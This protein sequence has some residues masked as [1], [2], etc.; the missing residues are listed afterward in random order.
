MTQPDFFQA[1]I[2]EGIIT[3]DQA[4]RLQDFAITFDRRDAEPGLAFGDDDAEAPRFVRGFHDILM[5]IG[6]G[7]GLGGLVAVVSIAGAVTAAP[8]IAA[9]AAWLLS[10]VIARRLR[11]GLPAAALAVAFALAGGYCVAPFLVEPGR[12]LAGDAWAGAAAFLSGSAAAMFYFWRFRVPLSLAIAVGALAA[13]IIAA[14]AAWRGTDAMGTT[15]DSLIL[16]LA[17]A[18][19]ALALAFDL[20][21]PERRTRRSDYAFWL[22]LIAA[23]ALIGSVMSFLVGFRFVFQAGGELDHGDAVVI[24]VVM[25]AMSVLALLI[26]RRA[27]LVAGLGFFAAA[28][29]SFTEEIGIEADLTT[30]VTALIL[31]ALIL[32]LALGWQDVRR[33]LLAVLPAAWTRRLPL[34]RSGAAARASAQNTNVMETG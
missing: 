11:L 29:F 6:I 14:Y 16:V 30:A 28:I 21:D 15:G 23:P 27:F 8:F 1:A 10:E 13:A 9:L 19:F 24:V 2:A 7:L 3:P 18:I 17:L 33:R 5:T 4:R 26:D 22:H 20:S 25:M 32:M 12:Q 31:G 34:V